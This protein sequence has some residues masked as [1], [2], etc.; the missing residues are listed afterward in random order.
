A[1]QQQQLTTRVSTP[2]PGDL[3][4][5]GDPAYH[6]GIYLGQGRMISAPHSGA[7]VHVVDVGT[8]TSYGRISGLGTITGPIIDTVGLGVQTVGA[9]ISD[10][11]GGV[12][13]TVL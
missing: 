10:V 4:F 2:L 8:P 3:V 11:L 6:V 12:R 9:S 5:F 1:A 7:T 13:A